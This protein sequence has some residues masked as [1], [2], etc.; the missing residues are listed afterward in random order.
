MEQALKQE[1]PIIAIN[2][3]GK[4]DLD[5][6]RCPVILKDKLVLHISF[7]QKIIEKAMAEWREISQN[8]KREAKFGPF[9][10]KPT[11]YSQLGL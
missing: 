3:N 7:N 9:S 1:I 2:L 4:R 10:Y 5:D 6:N 11:V 8:L